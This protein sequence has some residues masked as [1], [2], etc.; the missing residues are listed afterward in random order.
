[1]TGS[2]RALFAVDGSECSTAMMRCWSAWRGASGDAL[3]ALLL[4]AVPPPLHVWPTAGF[5]PGLIEEALRSIGRERLAGA[6]RWM[7]EGRV[8]WESVVRIGAPAQT[9]VA[10]AQRER[11]G[12]IVMGTRGLSALRGLLVGSM[13]LRV[14]QSSAIPVWLMPPHARCPVEL[15]R[16]LNL[17]VAVDGSDAANQAAVWAARTAPSFGECTIEL[18]SVR[19][20][21]APIGAA[22]RVP[23]EAIRNWCEE[24]GSAAIDVARAAMGV[25]GS[26]ATARIGDGPVVEELCRTAAQ[27]RADAIVVGSRRLGALGKAALGSVS[28]ALLQTSTCSVVVVRE[29]VE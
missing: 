4:T 27:T 3:K 2:L 28:S 13:A 17:L 1:M 29:A 8:P 14:V 7:Q 25:A 19:P 10:E 6:E 9:I 5:D 12:L 18:M 26:R 15:G 11:A 22:L 16:R 24:L 20:E 21:L 23:G